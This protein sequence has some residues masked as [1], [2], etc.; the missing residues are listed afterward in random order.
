MHQLESAIHRVAEFGCTVLVTGETGCGKEEVARAIHASG[1]RREKPFVVVNCGSLVASLA[2]SQLFGHERGAFTGAS[3]N[4]LGAFRAAA[5]GILFLDEIGEMPLELQ[6]KLLRVLQRCEVTP[7]GSTEAQPVDLQIIAATNRDLEQ[8][9][10]EQRFRED[11][12]YRLNTIHR[13]IPTAKPGSSHGRL[14]PP[15]HPPVSRCQ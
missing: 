6:P 7:V 11:L 5:G 1:P 2:E 8:E 3:A 12:L 10:A 15:R 4:S 9:V 13:A 14:R